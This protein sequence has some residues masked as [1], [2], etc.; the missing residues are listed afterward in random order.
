[1][2]VKQKP[3][4]ENK[5]KTLKTIQQTQSYSRCALGLGMKK[6]QIWMED[7]GTERSMQYLLRCYLLLIYSFIIPEFF[8]DKFSAL[9]QN[10]LIILP[11]EIIFKYT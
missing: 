8:Y 6:I 4:E 10:G 2:E 9:E 1:M 7:K 11:Y 3:K 5:G